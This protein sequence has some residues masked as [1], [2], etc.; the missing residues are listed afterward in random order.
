MKKQASSLDVVTIGSATHD[1]FVFSKSLS[2]TKSPKSESGYSECLELG[3]KSSVDKL[4][5]ATGGG[6]TNSATTFAR[7]GFRTVVCT[8]VG[9][10]NAGEM[11]REELK[12]LGITDY[13]HL[14]KGSK[15]ALSIILSQ[16]SKDRSILTYRGASEEITVANYPLN[17][18]SPRWFYL[19]SFHG[20]IA[21]V[22]SVLDR[23]EECDA[24]VAWNPGHSELALGLKKLKPIL[25]RIHVL[26][27]NREEAAE[28][29]SIKAANVNAL[30]EALAGIAEYTCV[31]DGSN[32]AWMC[33]A[34]DA[35]QIKC[36]DIPVASTTGAGDAFGS[37]LIAGFMKYGTPEQALRIALTNS[38]SVIQKI[39]A[40]EGILKE[41]PSENAMSRISVNKW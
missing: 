28:M 26:I 19:T 30:L 10:D 24:R 17:K 9:D 15:T 22:K 7:L 41:W 14:S 39:G 35:W 4:I 6:A 27:I 40:K 36:T 32:G 5:D 13:S 16:T 33:T 20:N 12:T 29:T 25:E 18:L 23:A 31:T 34:S 37:G 21:G 8:E 11:I 3:S 38:Q 2:I 1:L